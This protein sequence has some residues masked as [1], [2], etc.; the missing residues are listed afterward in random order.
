VLIIAQDPEDVEYLTRKLMEEY[1]KWGLKITKTHYM[2][3]GQNQIY[4][5]KEVN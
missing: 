5:W 1:K 2:C 4:Y 3:I